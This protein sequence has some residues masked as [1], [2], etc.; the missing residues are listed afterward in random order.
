MHHVNYNP[1]VNPNGG[2]EAGG[3]TFRGTESLKQLMIRP[4]VACLALA[5]AAIL[6]P[7]AVS[8]QSRCTH[9]TLNVRGT[10]VTIVYCVAGPPRSDASD[11]IV[12][13]VAASYAAPGGTFNRQRELRFVAGENASRILESLRLNRIGLTGVLHLTLVYA[14]GLVRVEGALLTPGGITIK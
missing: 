11:E 14:G 3:A 5:A 6:A 9:E 12:V 8:A 2:G 7:A 13:P 1:P 10:A 4:R